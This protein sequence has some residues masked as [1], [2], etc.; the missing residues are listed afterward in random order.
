MSANKT[1]CRPAFR[2]TCT[3]PERML[4]LVTRGL[5]EWR[6]QMLVISCRLQPM[7]ACDDAG[8]HPG[9]NLLAVKSSD[10]RHAAQGSS[11]SL[12]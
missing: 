10:T 5:V 4:L 12:L 11:P 2:R 3:S 1:C 7:L 8:R 9:P 6:L